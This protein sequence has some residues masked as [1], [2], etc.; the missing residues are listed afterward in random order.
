MGFFGFIILFFFIL[1]FILIS[2]GLSVV[3]YILR[4]FGLTTDRRSDKQQDA[5]NTWEKE[6]DSQQRKPANKKKII[7]EDEGEY[8]DYEE[9]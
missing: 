2:T 1:L 8:V 7:G 6:S 3:R 4:L 5:P 9:V